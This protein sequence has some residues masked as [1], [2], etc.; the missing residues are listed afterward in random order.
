MLKVHSLVFA[1]VLL[2]VLARAD[3]VINEI[4][5]DPDVKT[6]LVEF[7]ELYNSGAAPVSLTGWAFTAGIQFQFPAGTTI[8]AGG[9]LV[10]AENPGHIGLK[11]GKNAL[12]PWTG[13]LNNLGDEVVLRDG[14]GATVDKVDYQLGF[15]W[16]TV[17]DAPGNSIQLA[18]PAFDNDIGGHWRSALPTP[19]ARNSVYATN[20]PPAIR[21]VDNS[22]SQPAANQPTRI[23]AKVTDPEG[24]ASVQLQY[25]VVSPGNYIEL[26]DATYATSWTGLAMNDS[27]AD[28]DELA[29]DSIYTATIPASVQTNRRL[30]RYRILASDASGK[31]V[32]V[33]YADDPSPNFAYFCYNGVPAWSG[34]IN[35]ASADF[36]LAFPQV[37]STNVMRSLPVYHLI[38]KKASVEASTWIERYADNDYKWAGTIVYDSKVYDHVHYR[39][40]G[41][42]WRYAM[43]K[44][45]WKFDFGRGHDFQARD[46]W[47][48]EYKTKWT[49][50]N[51]GACIQQGDYL[52]RGEQGM[53]ESIGF[54]LFNLA[55]LE[56]PK[57]NFAQFRVIDEASENGT[58][59]YSGDFW[60][61]YLA[62]EQEDLR[63]LDEHHLP[64][65]NFY[66]M[67]G[68]FGTLN[69]QGPYG[70]TD[71]SDLWDFLTSI[72]STQPEAWWRRNFDL[73]KYYS[74]R[75]IVEGIHHYDIDGN[76]GKNYFYY[77]NDLTGKWEVHSWDLDLTWADNMYG[78]G[79][80][81]FKTRVLPIANLNRE[82]KNRIREIRDL[83]FNT[84]EAYKLIDEYANMIWRTNAPSFV[85]AD[86]A[87]WDYNPIMVSS[88]VN[89]SKAGQGRFYQAAATKDFPGMV[90]LMK[91]YVVSRG[92]SL[93]LLAGDAGT[94]AK[95]TITNL[96]PTGNPANRLAFQS[97]AYSGGT[98]G[99]AMKWR[100]GEI[101]PSAGRPAFDQDNPRVY[102]IEPLWESAETSLTPG[103]VQIPSGIVKVGHTYRARVRHKDTAGR[104]SN[105][106]APAEFVA[107]EPDNA[108][109]LVENLR[110][111]ELMYNPPLGSDY[112]F[113]ELYNNSADTTLDLAGV[114]FTAGI[115]Y[116][117]SSPAQLAP[118]AYCLVTRTA[119]IA[120]FRAYYG[121]SQSLPIF[122]P[123]SGSL[124]NDGE[125]ITLKTT[126][127][128]ATIVDFTYG[129]N[130]SWP[131]A[132]DGAGHSLVAL[133]PNVPMDA[134]DFSYSGNWRASEFIKGSP[135]AGEKISNGP[136]INEVMA[137]TSLN[138]PN[139]PQYAS[140]DWIELGNPT[141]STIDWANFYLSDDSANL[142]KWPLPGGTLAPGGRIVFDEITGFHSP[143][144]NGFGIDHGGEEIYLS[145]LPGTGVDRVVDAV[146]FKGQSLDGSWAR[147]PDMT[148]FWRSAVPSQGAANTKPRSDLTITEVMYHPST[149][150]NSTADNTLDEF[151][152]IFNAS[153]IDQSLSTTN[154]AF[155]ID[156]GIS[157]TFPTNLVL[158]AGQALLL[159]NFNPALA[160]SSNAFRARFNVPD[161]VRI[162]G[163]YS[164]KLGNNSDRVAIERP[165]RPPVVGDPYAWVVLDQVTYGRRPLWP[166]QA[167]GQGSSLQRISAFAAGNDPA[168][169]QAALPTAGTFD[170]NASV[171][172]IASGQIT[173]DQFSIRAYLIAGKSYVLQ[174]CD[175]LGAPQ[176][177]TAATQ[178]PSSTGWVD[179]T[180]TRPATAGGRYYRLA[181]QP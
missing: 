40:R 23:T 167:D 88:Y 123:Y 85:G 77:T 78:S 16:P 34:A 103:S 36:S 122:G 152:E 157:Y 42:V 124:N 74:Y 173:A 106:S 162:L 63:F 68:G 133:F 29:G 170:A 75:T 18:N 70:P 143:I 100:L 169:W 79:N 48:H 119:N 180:D 144:T 99:S 136:V 2:P 27:G 142:K 112:E 17:G 51:L 47:G 73:N 134:G 104:W 130:G 72:N 21:Q 90:K 31:S 64:D 102:E 32:T 125:Q 8:P 13:S 174:Y 93:D 96:S 1:A 80:E 153:A 171:L 9:Y 6:E 115:D 55:G 148:G 156:G 181:Q 163:P 178:T 54:R 139:F 165:E 66:K 129:D 145:Y 160:A 94:P 175:D 4:H 140:N 159:V 154:G 126:A 67:E 128:G 166:L 30:I 10:V 111:T 11:F 69:N 59:Q 49:K 98:A 176:W 161:G 158:N 44:N 24:V 60:G 35:P 179:L 138:D 86:R 89:P 82:Y 172:S 7:I 147:V 41:G 61:L 43:G 114:K 37:Y 155:R 132:A 65:S 149:N 137:N 25:Q 20:L 5:Y 45:M 97:S 57:S 46:N 127:S 83:L 95:P 38:S 135:G 151:V 120:A 26:T 168:N 81:Q 53:Y 3:V 33:P 15:P 121:L 118:H 131:V 76:P 117:F 150:A 177:Q 39:A 146:K 164:G 141:A 108:A 113:I 50:L 109:A 58:N 52:H 116:T 28:G 12:G 101:T 87:M 71:G 107:G 84:D 14:N 22:P 92:N 110:L 105:W 91:D 19:G 62:I 56:A